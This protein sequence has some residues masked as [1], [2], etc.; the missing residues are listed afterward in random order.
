MSHDAT[1]PPS[2]S[3]RDAKT[4][5]PGQGSPP[6]LLHLKGSSYERGSQYGKQAK[7]RIDRSI[8][9]YKLMFES[10][11]ISWN[12]AIDKAL[13]CLDAALQ[14]F[15]YIDDELRGIADGSGHDY[16]SLAALNC[17]TEILPPDYLARASG[18][19]PDDLPDNGHISECTS[20]ALSGADETVWL[21]QNWDW[22]GMQ[23][24][25]LVV[26]KSEPTT[27]GSETNNENNGSYLTVSEAGMLAK[28]GLN[29]KGLGITL[30]ILRSR[31]DGTRPGVPVHLFLRGILDCDSV[32]EVISLASSLQFAS[33]SNIMIADKQGDRASLEIS[34]M[35]AKILH[36]T[37]GNGNLLCHTN[38]FIHPELSGDDAGLTGNLSTESRLHRAEEMVK[39]ATDLSD[40]TRVLSDTS[41]G[42]QSICRFPDQSL[43][44]HAQVETVTAVAMDLTKLELWIS[45]RQASVSKLHRIAL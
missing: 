28:I 21:S 35:G 12:Q 31:H 41:D 10:C 16:R 33:S 26:I 2:D 5:D 38:H 15:P 19:S 24:S 1:Q 23:R 8:S 7:E 36:P 18:L 14:H 39:D 45:P 43:P 37:A 30:N 3:Q 22:I 44:V 34:P 27:H 20:F 32:E 42:L 11:G 4:L 17:R 29:S 25:A 6:P 40:I 13:P 9:T